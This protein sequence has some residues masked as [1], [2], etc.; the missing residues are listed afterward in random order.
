MKKIILLSLLLLL[1]Y[2]TCYAETN[3]IIAEGTYVMGDDDTP[4]IAE[5]RALINAK[6]MALEQA[7][8]YLASYSKTINL[9]LTKDEIETIAKGSLQTTVIDKKRMP[10]SEGTLNFWVKIRCIVNTDDIKSE[11]I[12]PRSDMPSVENYLQGHWVTESGNTHYYFDEGK[13]LMVENFSTMPMTYKLLRYG[14]DW[15]LIKV[16]TNYNKGHEKYLKFLNKLHTQLQQTIEFEFL[17]NK[18]ISKNIWN[19]VDNKVK[20]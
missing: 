7:G 6:R 11:N 1:F 2:G 10:N 18:T 9:E 3:E 19:R 12:K 16:T 20:P 4:A 17:G 15:V 8:T 14:E 5:E 13:L